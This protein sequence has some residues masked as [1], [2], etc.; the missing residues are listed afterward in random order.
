LVEVNLRY[1]DAH[2]ISWMVS[3]YEPGKLIQE[4]SLLAATT[5]EDGWTCGH[6]SAEAGLGRVV[7]AY[8]RSTVERGL[9]VVSTG[10]GPD[11]ARGGYAIAYGPVMAERDAAGTG[12][13]L[14]GG[15]KAAG[16]SSRFGA[17]F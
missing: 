15:C 16:G 9:F 4:A 1:F 2:G 10:G 11:V 13:R 12:P 3:A 7:Q 14:P 8:M 17:G 6:P 5:L